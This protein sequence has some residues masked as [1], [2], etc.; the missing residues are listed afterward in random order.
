MVASE[1]D[2]LGDI[3]LPFQRKWLADDSQ[4]KISDKSRQIGFS[5]I[6]AFD[7]ALLAAKPDGMDTWVVHLNEDS[8]R[9]WIGDVAFWARFLQHASSEIQEIA[10][11]NE[12][13]D[14]KA[15]RIQFASGWR[16][17]ALS[18]RPSNLRGKRGKVVIE[19]AAFHDSL[20]ELIKAAM[21]FLMWNGKVTIISTHNGENSE[22]NQ[23]LNECRAGKKD[24][25][26][27]RCTFDEAIAE[28]L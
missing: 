22:Y 3:F 23:L 6:E 12:N 18:S 17:T 5:W 2:A 1:V 21:A 19:E 10:V 28:G 26:V 15:F 24:W 7:S 16:V 11:R 8:A 27:H 25:S 4:V 9:E 14:I 13:N 20:S